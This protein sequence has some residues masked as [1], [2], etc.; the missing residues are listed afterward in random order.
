ML[1]TVNS[2]PIEV[3]SAASVADLVALLQ[4]PSTRVAVELNRQL[5]R[6][7]DHGAT[8]LSPGDTVEVVTLVGGG[9]AR[10]VERSRSSA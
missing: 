2:Q 8:T 4:L 1:I 5:V 7:S 9:S 10:M 3:P 6:R